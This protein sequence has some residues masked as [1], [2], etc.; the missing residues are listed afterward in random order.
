L[1]NPRRLGAGVWATPADATSMHFSSCRLILRFYTK[2][3]R[4]LGAAPK[5]DERCA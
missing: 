3:N 2:K 4:P 1:R 5:G